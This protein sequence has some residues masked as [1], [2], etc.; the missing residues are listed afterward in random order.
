MQHLEGSKRKTKV[1]FSV[2]DTFK[3]CVIYL[4]CHNGFCFFCFSKSDHHLF[5]EISLQFIGFF[6]QPRKGSGNRERKLETVKKIVATAEKC[7]KA[8]K[9]R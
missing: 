3:L 8:V 6:L 4:L 7:L 5:F 1:Y 9:K 2:I